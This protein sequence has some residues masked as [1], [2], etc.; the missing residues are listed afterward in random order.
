MAAL[1]PYSESLERVRSVLVFFV[2]TGPANVAV[3]AELEAEVRSATLEGG[4]ARMSLRDI[5]TDLELL[6]AVTL[7]ESA[8]ASASAMMKRWAV[9]SF[10]RTPAPR[11]VDQNNLHS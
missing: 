10:E 2:A 4:I 11:P 5:Q 9:G 6:A 1:T 3:L 7:V 8:A